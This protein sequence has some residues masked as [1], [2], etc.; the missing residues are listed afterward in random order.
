LLISEA[1][2]AG[3]RIPVARF[4][5]LCDSVWLALSLS[6][7]LSRSLSTGKRKVDLF[8]A[9]GRQLESGCVVIGRQ[10]AHGGWDEV[11][12]A[13]LVEPVSSHTD[14][15][16]QVECRRAPA[17]RRHPATSHQAASARSCKL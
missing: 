12:R 7:R 11:D 15:Q 4:A 1:E 17:P 13:V 16:R 5:L 6:L 3:A 14:R 2:A 9:I 10:A 8:A